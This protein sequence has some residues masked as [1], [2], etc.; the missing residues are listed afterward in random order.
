[1]SSLSIMGVERWCDV[2]AWCAPV[3]PCAP[4]GW[5]Q[6]AI[7]H[8][9]TLEGPLL[10]ALTQFKPDNFNHRTINRFALDWTC[11][12]QDVGRWQKTFLE[13]LRGDKLVAVSMF[14][15]PWINTELPGA[16]HL[17][18]KCSPELP[19]HGMCL[20]GLW[21]WVSPSTSLV[22]PGGPPWIASPLC[23]AFM[24]KNRHIL[25]TNRFSHSHLRLWLWMVD[26]WNV[27]QRR[28]TDVDLISP[29]LDRSGCLIWYACATFC[30]LFKA[31]SRCLFRLSRAVLLYCDN[32]LSTLVLLWTLTD[33][34]FDSKYVVWKSKHASALSQS[35]TILLSHPPLVQS[36]NWYKY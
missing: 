21:C 26:V 29:V 7:A 19:G 10:S 13:A 18:K 36:L 11:D 22:W 33:H 25:T 2:C 34:R 23:G 20:S 1:M 4:R 6:C 3:S 24:E 15:L 32:V 8:T 31:V 28:L 30:L 35:W 17:Q 27:S 12:H 16:F 9:P 5:K 14:S